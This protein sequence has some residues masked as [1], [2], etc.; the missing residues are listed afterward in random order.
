M[1]RFGLENVRDEGE[2]YEIKS[3]CVVCKEYL[4][5]IGCPFGRFT[6]L[7]KDK[8][9]GCME[10]MERVLG[11]EKEF[12]VMSNSVF[13]YKNVDDKVREQL[14]KLVKEGGEKIKWIKDLK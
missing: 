1:R 2:I 7:T 12:E 5:C 9:L 14:K 13:W 10:W 8:R 4:K 11:E 3:Q 6:D